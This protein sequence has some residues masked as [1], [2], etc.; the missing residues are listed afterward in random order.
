MKSLL[1]RLTLGVS[2]LDITPDEAKYVQKWLAKK[3]L[4]K[5]ENQYKF[6]SKYR[7]GTLG[8]VQKET[9]YL[10]VIG[11]NVRDLLIEDLGVATEGDLIIA[12]RLLGKRGTPSAKIAEI[13]GREQSYS[14]AY[15]IFKDNHKVLS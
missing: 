10:N 6:N 3:Y 11:E 5:K 1:I 4:T 12:Q 13:V 9:A 7:A 15:I 8:L 14:I 2:E